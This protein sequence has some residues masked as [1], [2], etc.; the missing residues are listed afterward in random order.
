MQPNGLWC[1]SNDF[2]MRK[3]LVLAVLALPAWST[4]GEEDPYKDPALNVNARYIVES[5]DIKGAARARLLLSGP[6]R[7]EI[8]QVVGQNYDEPA[9]KRLADRIK[10][11]LR[12]PEV[13]VQVRKGRMPDR[14]VVTFEVGQDEK[15]FDLDLVRF[16]YHSRQGWTGEGGATIRIRG[17]K[18]SFGLV[19]DGDRLAERYAG[20]QAGY[21]RAF[22]G[23]DRLG[24]R[25]RFLSYHQQWNRATLLAAPASDIYRER[26]HFVPET[27]IQI[28]EALQ[29]SAGLDF[30]RYRMAQPS[31]V[32]S[33]PSGARTESSNAVVST[34]RYHQRWDSGNGQEQEINASYGLRSATAVLASDAIYTRQQGELRYRLR[35]G[36]HDMRLGFL[37]G[38]IAGRAPMYERF[39]LGNAETLRGW[40]KFDLDPA[41]GSN[42]VHGSID[43]AWRRFLI[44]YDTGAIWTLAEER[45]QKQSLGAGIREGAFELAVAFPIR[46]GRV[47]PVFYVGLN[48]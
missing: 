18:L 1:A 42:V 40:N 16:L 19:S 3:L 33:A 25:F 6:L 8:N 31:P 21:E 46:T 4:T 48:F 26:M 13:S 36:N 35:R 44:F 11:E 32:A 38:R 15:G 30:A 9:L 12:V 22:L 24:L 23:T 41:G 47:K 2:S 37:A 34:L 17:N 39:V 5:V 29:W 7:T 27:T 14:L 20:I 43:Y 10:D 28:A 45:E